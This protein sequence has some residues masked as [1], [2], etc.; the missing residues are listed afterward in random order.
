MKFNVGDTVRVAKSAVS[1]LI[2]IEG[3]IVS[4]EPDG[5]P[6][7]TRYTLQMDAGQRQHFLEYQ[8]EFV[9]RGD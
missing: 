1:D 5:D 3:V 6:T 7:F 9:R 2:G 4:T 8:L